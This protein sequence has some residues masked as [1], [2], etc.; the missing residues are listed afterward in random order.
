MKVTAARVLLFALCGA[1]LGALAGVWFGGDFWLRSET[2]QRGLQSIAA[3]TA[4]APPPG[5]VPAR[6]GEPMPPISLPDLAGVARALP[7]DYPGTPLLINVWASWCGPC[8][9]EMPELE[10]FGQARGRHGIQVIGL[11]LDEAEAIRRFL[12][13]VPVSYPILV[14]R[15]GPADA[16]VWLGNTRG[17]LPYTVLVGADGRIVR[18][19]LGPFARGEIERWATHAD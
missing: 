1:A 6:P 9:E 15:P 11:A 2:G 16:S 17:L 18:Q 3:G 8:V 10:S 14:D 5:V 13:R 19:K 7:G 12:D 4:P